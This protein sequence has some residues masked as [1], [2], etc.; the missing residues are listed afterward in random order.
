MET[1]YINVP[2]SPFVVYSYCLVESQN[3][4]NHLIGRLSS[5]F[6]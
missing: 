4:G 5:E 3:G 1:C 2:V 6:E